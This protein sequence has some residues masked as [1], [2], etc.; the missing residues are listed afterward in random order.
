MPA[1]YGSVTPSVAAAAT[2]ASTALPPRRRTSTAT[3]VASGSTV[4][5][6]PPWPTAVGALAD[7]E[8]DV[9]SA[10]VAGEVVAA[11]AAPCIPVAVMTTANAPRKASRAVRPLP[12]GRCP[13]ARVA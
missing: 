13:A 5:A 10:A 4:A 8:A 1:E 6:A 9:V 12:L 3:R 2:A 11:A 7:A